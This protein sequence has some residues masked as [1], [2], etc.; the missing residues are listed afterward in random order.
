MAMTLFEES[1]LYLIEA[2]P[3]LLF[4]VLLS[5]GGASGA[6]AGYMATS[7]PHRPVCINGHLATTSSPSQRADST[8]MISL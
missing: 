4:V 1:Q 3:S 5:A 8:S 7:A 6:E 2:V